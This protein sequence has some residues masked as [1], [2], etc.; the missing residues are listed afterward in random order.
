MPLQ[1]RHAQVKL[2]FVTKDVPVSPAGVCS[3]VLEQRSR[4]RNAISHSLRPKVVSIA[5]LNKLVSYIAKPTMAED[6]L[7]H[8]LN[9]IYGVSGEGNTWRNWHV[10]E[11]K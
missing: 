9:R 10:V 8:N 7:Y 6:R 3:E 2:Y 5:V 11:P 1:Y 4:K